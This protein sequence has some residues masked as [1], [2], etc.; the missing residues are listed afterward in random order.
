MNFSHDCSNDSTSGDE[1]LGSL[2][3][4]SDYDRFSGHAT[5]CHPQSRIVIA[6]GRG[7]CDFS[8]FSHNTQSA[9]NFQLNLWHFVP[10]S[11]YHFVRY[12]R[13]CM[14]HSS[15]RLQGCNFV[16]ALGYPRVKPSMAD[17]KVRNANDARARPRE[18]DPFV[19][20]K[21]TETWRWKDKEDF[22][23]W[24]HRRH[25]PFNAEEGIR[26][27]TRHCTTYNADI[28]LTESGNLAVRIHHAE[29]PVQGDLLA[30]DGITM[31]GAVG[32]VPL[33]GP[34]YNARNDGDRTSYKRLMVNKRARN[35]TT[36][37]RSSAEMAA[38]LFKNFN[39]AGPT[40]KMKEAKQPALQ[41]QVCRQVHGTPGV[42][43]L[44][45]SL[46]APSHAMHADCTRHHLASGHPTHG[47]LPREAPCHNAM[48]HPES[49]T[50]KL[51]RQFAALRGLA[52][53][54]NLAEFVAK[55][56]QWRSR[57]PRTDDDATSTM[58]GK[59]ATPRTE[60]MTP[61][62]S[63]QKR[64]A[65]PPS[66]PPPPHLLPPNWQPDAAERLWTPNRGS[67]S[68]SP[69]RDRW[70]FRSVSPVERHQE[71][72]ARPSLG[73]LPKSGK[74]PLPRP[75]QAAEHMRRYPKIARA[76]KRLIVPPR[77]ANKQSINAPA[78]NAATQ[79]LIQ[80]FHAMS[81]SEAAAPATTPQLQSDDPGGH[82][83]AL[84]LGC[85]LQKL[86]DDGAVVAAYDNYG[87]P[88]GG[89]YEFL[90]Q[91]MARPGGFATLKAIVRAP[92]LPTHAKSL[93]LLQAIG[94]PIAA[95]ALH[96]NVVRSPSPAES[97]GSSVSSTASHT[98]TR[99]REEASAAP[100]SPSPE[101]WVLPQ[102]PSSAA[103]DAAD[104]PGAA[105]STSF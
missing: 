69:T 83:T 57:R 15:G 61:P 99:Q 33:A 31:E 35:D 27:W 4:A 98:L 19:K 23:D 18:E 40:P 80:E 25:E 66:T 85:K 1:W 10:S 74:A 47:D 37:E 58:H 96:A 78:R 14:A 55:D 26:H 48:P 81:H 77:A 50:S 104:V 64:T 102:T 72:P 24:H 13:L 44:P 75:T 54:R 7:D 73:Q 51:D 86:D 2:R 100:S 63:G 9:R 3:R 16:H 65:K 67:P 103:V 97:S 11:S 53:K 91:A 45:A 88:Q 59:N 42:P 71:R 90:A 38:S 30:A 8:S 12:Q 94:A 60:V 56:S 82:A 32:A 22:L 34:L 43:G 41:P 28:G 93:T 92:D 105:G 70:I 87:G 29:L 49:P 36:P 62:Q 79:E 95:A 21:T 46:G 89:F 6:I 20:P 68:T 17:S 76:P 39:S 101:L 84:G 5:A 52:A